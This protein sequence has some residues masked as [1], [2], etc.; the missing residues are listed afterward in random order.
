MITIYAIIHPVTRE[1]VYI[2]RTTQ[3]M[4]SRLV[5]HI[6]EDSKS[7]KTKWIQNLV[8]TGL[9]PEII[10]I[11]KTD[12][13][14]RENYWISHYKSIGVSLFNI[15]SGGFRENARRPLKYGVPTKMINTRVPENRIKEFRKAVAAILKQWEIKPPKP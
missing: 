7:E 11:E 6:R 2:G 9:M 13:P 5:G 14:G 8:S 10:E 12:D 3:L 4:I 15:G 1:V